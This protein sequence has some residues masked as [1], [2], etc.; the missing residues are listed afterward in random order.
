MIDLPI[1]KSSINTQI[2]IGIR[3]FEALFVFIISL[4]S[5]HGK[6]RTLI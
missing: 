3:V 2:I 1:I 6:I 4:R 5:Y